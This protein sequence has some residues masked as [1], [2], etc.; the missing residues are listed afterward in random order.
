[1][2]KQTGR[3]IKELQ[4]GIVERYTNQFL[5][6]GQNIHIGTHFTNGLYRLAKK[7]NCSLLEKAWY[8]LFNAQLDISF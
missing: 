3:K 7:I 2:E 4:I 6:F 1:M 8:L 5:R